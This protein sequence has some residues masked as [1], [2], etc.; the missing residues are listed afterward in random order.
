[1]KGLDGHQPGHLQAPADRTEARTLVVVSSF[2]E[3]P[4]P[5]GCTITFA[6]WEGRYYLNSN[7]L[8]SSCQHPVQTRICLAG[9]LLPCAVLKKN[10]PHYSGQNSEEL[11]HTPHAHFEQSP[12]LIFPTRRGRHPTLALLNRPYTALVKARTPWSPCFGPCH[13]HPPSQGMPA[14]GPCRPAATR[15]ALPCRFH[16]ALP[17]SEVAQLLVFIS[18]NRR[19]EIL[20]CFL[21]IPSLARS[22]PPA[23][24]SPTGDNSPPPCWR[25][26][27]ATKTE[28]G[29]V[30][31]GAHSAAMPPATHSK[32]LSRAAPPSCRP[33]PAAASWSTH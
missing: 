32:R 22:R 17:H 11:L 25:R 12:N 19:K 21:L 24:R 23:A 13:H 3:A 2:E 18:K 10:Q 9:D 14:K 8:Q 31:A 27:M 20:A 26:G 5:L 29:M 15:T 16:K 30:H 6:S 33:P 1:M 4:L 28:I 7:I